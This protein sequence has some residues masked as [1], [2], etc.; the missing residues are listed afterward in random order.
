MSATAAQ[1]ACDRG[2]A[3]SVA[4]GPSNEPHVEHPRLLLATT[5]LASSL[6]FIDGSVVS[7]ALP[8]MGRSF[9]AGGGGLSWV[10][11]GYTLPLSALLLIGG[12]A[13]DVFGRRRLLIVGVASFALASLLCALAP[14]LALLVAGR[15]AQ[16][17]GAALLMPNSLAI[18]GAGFRGEARGRAIGAW[19]AIGAAAGAVGPILGGYLI[20][21]VGWRAIFLIN[22]PIAGAAIVLAARF[23]G[24][25]P[26]TDR[27][28]LDWLGAALAALALTAITWGLT[29]A[30]AKQAVELGSGGAVLLGAAAAAGFVWLERRKR[31]A[32]M[33]PLT[34][35]SS[36]S[37]V[38]L[39]VL[40]FLLYGALGGLLV[41]VPFV[42]I[43]ASQYSA[44]GAG[45]ALLPLP[46]VIAVSSS[47]M[48]QLA[49]RIGSRLPLTVGPL[50]VAA[51]CVLA[52][53]I[54]EPGSYFVTVLPAL[55]VISIGMA[56][57]VAPLTTGVLSSVDEQHT[58]VA[59]GF[60]SA[61]ARTGGLV[62][63][64]FV[65]A[66]LAARGTE[67]LTLFRRAALV[68]A[69][70]CVCA[71]LAAFLCLSGKNAEP[72]AGR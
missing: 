65:S 61:V 54:G 12:A 71:A 59:S 13:G 20:D 8:A 5:I 55:L 45:A 47:W 35:F 31:D 40:T 62:A 9:G 1:P 23:V 14:T 67:L 32:A 11:N 19:A 39:S 57:A 15:V 34:L 63:V 22:L 72:A 6:A 30:S 52:L 44:A 64:A 46:L 51:G 25:D 38:G 42:L 41:L 24:R 48:G 58:G 2:I 53:R 69:V 4:P 10:V 70:A 33:L 56:G 37:F 36:R 28:R 60:N 18:L 27:K 43:E 21:W 68:G 16:G 49:A 3:H 50:L 66:V 7:V 26:A 17:V 29:V